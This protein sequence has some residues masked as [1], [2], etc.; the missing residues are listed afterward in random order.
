MY[1]WKCWQ[2]NI[3]TCCTNI[4]KKCWTNIYS[5]KSW[6]NISVGKSGSHIYQRKVAPTFSK[7]M[8]TSISKKW[9]STFF[10]GGCRPDPATPFFY[11]PLFFIYNPFDLT[12]YT[13]Q[14]MRR[15]LAFVFL[16]N[17]VDI[18]LMIW[19]LQLLTLQNISHIKPN[20]IPVLVSISRCSSPPAAGD[21]S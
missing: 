20:Y 16:E 4:L 2:N 13:Y 15:M 6:I 9:I 11:K 17:Q 10:L 1:F 3:Q 12:G 14:I 7:E 21:W 18:S 19:W 8:V 5:K